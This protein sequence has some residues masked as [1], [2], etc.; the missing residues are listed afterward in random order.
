MTTLS[1]LRNLAAQ[2]TLEEKAQ[3]RQ[4]IEDGFPDDP[5]EAI[6]ALAE[7]LAFIGASRQ[8]SPE[9]NYKA[10]LQRLAEIA[11]LFSSFNLS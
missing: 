7:K 4:F 9:E 10:A 2:L 3:L 5:S 8:L 1:E 11:A 6:Q